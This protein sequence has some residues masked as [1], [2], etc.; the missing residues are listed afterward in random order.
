MRAA[1]GDAILVVHFV[2]I[3][4]NIGGLV[5]IPLGAALGWRFVRIAWLRL[6]HLALLYGPGGLSL[7][8]VASFATEAGIA[9]LCDVSLLDRLAFLLDLG[10]FSMHALLTPEHE[11]ADLEAEGFVAVRYYPFIAVANVARCQVCARGLQGDALGA[12][13]GLTSP[14]SAPR[15]FISVSV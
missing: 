13:I 7:R 9:D 15:N 14:Q 6:L 2:I 11:A 8:G 4:F 5:V 3:V 1:L 12:G 10:A